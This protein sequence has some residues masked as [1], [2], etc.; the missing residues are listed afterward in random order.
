MESIFFIHSLGI[1]PS[2][3]KRGIAQTLV[4]LSLEVTDPLSDVIVDIR[5]A[6]NVYV[7]LL[8]TFRIGFFSWPITC[9][10]IVQLPWQLVR[11]QEKYL[12]RWNFKP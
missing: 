11:I 12:K 10:M 9:L 1:D 6:N 2:H 7:H 3:R 4:K 5:E 8:L